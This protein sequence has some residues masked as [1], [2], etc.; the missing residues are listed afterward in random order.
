MSDLRRL[1]TL[2]PCSYCGASEDEP[3]RTSSGARATYPHSARTEP[4]YAAWRDGFY[5]G[6]ADILGA[7]ASAEQGD[8][9]GSRYIEH[10][11]KHAA[12]LSGDPA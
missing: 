8:S 3:C 10:A 11:R 5:D 1:A 2:I 6:Q 9:W 12:D 4:I 7:L